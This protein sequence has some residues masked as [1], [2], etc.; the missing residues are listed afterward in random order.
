KYS[1]GPVY[2]SQM[3][4]ARVQAALAHRRKMR[5]EQL[6]QA[7][8]EPATQDIRPFALWPTL[9]RVLGT[10]SDPRLRNA[11]ALLDH[12][13]ADG[14]HRRDLDRNGTDEDDDAITLMD[15]WWPR[16]VNTEFHPSLGDDAFG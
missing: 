6:V 5:I 14:G 10:P 12:W 4:A 16:L 1:F 15:A 11:I 9:R 2:R 7:M 3:I 8:E 13:Y